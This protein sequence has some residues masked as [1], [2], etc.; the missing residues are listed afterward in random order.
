[1]RNLNTSR[2]RNDY[3]YVPTVGKCSYRSSSQAGFDTVNNDIKESVD[4][5]TDDVVTNN[6]TIRSARGEVINNDYRSVRVVREDSP[7]IAYW[8]YSNS[9]DGGW[10]NCQHT[11]YPTSK[12]LSYWK[13]NRGVSHSWGLLEPPAYEYDNLVNATLA[14]AFANV[15]DSEAQILVSFAEAKK[16]AQTV[17][18]ILSKLVGVVRGFRNYRRSL[19][20]LKRRGGTKLTKD[21]AKQWLEL[22]YGVRPLYYDAMNL[23]SAIDQAKR[24]RPRMKFTARKSYETSADEPYTHLVGIRQCQGRMTYTRNITVSAGVQTQVDMNR[25]HQLARPFGLGEI[26]QSG[27]ELV[28]FS[29]MIDWFL[30]IG[31]LIGAWS[32]KAGTKVLGSYVTVKDILVQTC[33]IDDVSFPTYSGNPNV[34][35]TGYCTNGLYR[36]TT[37]ITTRYANPSPP[38]IPSLDINLDVSKV[39][40]IL[41]LIRSLR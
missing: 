1:M 6:Y 30:N 34:D 18:S 22:R 15:S 17:V 36:K 32:P 10:S 24:D 7:V 13:D 25:I 28:P 31:D 39:V 21:M 19:T 29:F 26:F 40:D 16:T 14:R 5:T 3:S 23:M 38:L 41:A 9:D 2:H 37:T 11:G 27:W 35:M 12:Y 20:L 4:L 8:S 33:T